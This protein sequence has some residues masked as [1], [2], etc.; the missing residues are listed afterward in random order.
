MKTKDR[1]SELEDQVAA[2]QLELAILRAQQAVKI[3]Q[4][5]PWQPYPYTYPPYTTGPLKIWC[6]GVTSSTMKSAAR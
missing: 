3:V 4:T 2:L 1:I 5:P 6:G